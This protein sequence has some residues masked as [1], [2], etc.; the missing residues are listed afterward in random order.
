MEKVFLC[1][2]LNFRK[3]YCIDRYF[4]NILKLSYP[5][6]E[7]YFVDNSPSPFYAMSK[8]KK[9]GLDIDWLDPKRMRNQ[10]YIRDSMNVIRRKF[11]D[12]KCDY[13]FVLECDLFP[14][15]DII[16][17]LLSHEAQVVAAPYFL[18]NGANSFLSDT[19][20]EDSF[21]ETINNRNIGWH[22]SF[23]NFKGITTTAKQC[24]MGCVMIRRDVMEQMDFFTAHDVPAH[25]DTFFYFALNDLGIKT[26]YD[27]EIIVTHENRSWTTVKDAQQ[28]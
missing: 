19:D 23:L 28:H 9:W 3:E 2:P 27:T 12:S 1:S 15:L 21:G 7:F 20:I 17:R 11:L 10:D 18:G 25:H 4:S 22:E 8:I 26:L 13:M 5:H 6:K 14:P 24:G 16:E